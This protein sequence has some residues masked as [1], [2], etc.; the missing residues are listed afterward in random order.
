V[1][2]IGATPTVASFMSEGDKGDKV[3]HGAHNIKAIFPEPSNSENMA[4]HFLHLK[5]AKELQ[6]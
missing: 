4:F 2:I 5:L 6:Q 3:L 1:R